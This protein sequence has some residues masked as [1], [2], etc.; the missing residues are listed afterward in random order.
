MKIKL[1]GSP[2]IIMSNHDSKHAYFGWPTAI[3]L[4]NGR[5]AVGAS[6]FRLGHLDPFGKAVLSF[7]DN[8]GETYTPPAVVID[9]PLDDRDTGLCTFGESGLILTSFNN[10]RAMQRSW[11]EVDCT[12]EE[13]AY[14][15]AYLNCISDEEEEKYLG[16]TFKI[17]YDCGITF[18]PL[19]KT[20]VS[21]PHGPIQLQNGEILWVGRADNVFNVKGYRDCIEAH[22]LNPK[23][24]STKKIG[25][26][27][28][29]RLDGKELISCE[30]YAFQID[31]G[32]VICHIRVEPSFTTYQSVSR[33]NGRTW[34][35][36]EALLGCKGG[37]PA[38]IIK[39]SS[40]I[41]IS[42]YGYREAP[43]GIKAML[44]YDNGLT[45]NTENRIYT[46]DVSGDIGYPSTV[47]LSDGSLITVF[48]AR[49]DKS[50]PRTAVIM[51]Q[52]WRLE[53]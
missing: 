38:H 34:S 42:V 29:I 17:S 41:L 33:D 52:K 2:K 28:N 22:I 18:G 7:S 20:T 26:I 31:D 47:E 45:W 51:Q 6:G 1:I 35:V 12:E 48:Y 23:S 21:S 43:F 4:Q 53:P 3:K 5:L 25:E 11:C 10:T 40:G 36:P 9:S 49:P 44:S 46:N 15:R 39:H 32:T 27:D 24:G 14:N 13:M 50:N 30:P 8:E 37:A 19:C 16:S